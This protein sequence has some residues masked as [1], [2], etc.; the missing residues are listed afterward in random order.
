[1]TVWLNGALYAPELARIDPSDRGFTLGD[2]VFETIRLF[3]GK[4]MHLARHLRRLRDGA[5][6][7]GIPVLYEDAAIAAAIVAVT[8]VPGPMEAVARVTLTR[9]PA[10]RGVMPPV[11]PTP[12]LLVV[13]GTPPPAVASVRAII[14]GSTRRN[15]ASP[16]SRIKS[17]NYLDNVLAR[18]EAARRAADEA[19]L[20][21]TR[22]ALAEASAA[23]LFLLRDGRLVTPPLADGALPGVIRA[24]LIE[25]CGAVE[26]SIFPDD[27]FAAGGAFLS[28]SLG[29]RIISEVDGRP[30][31]RND[32]WI[33]ECTDTA[34]VE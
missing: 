18:Q 13:P 7:L 17:L 8:S 22:G 26:Q 32:D 23:N 19:L 30:I 33:I 11:S 28:S 21:N 5:Q 6:V 15:E 20:L 10:P 29:M 14:S 34:A 25:R 3:G 16:L 1:M 24:L 31:R 4:P 27:L 9:G 2:G 12:T